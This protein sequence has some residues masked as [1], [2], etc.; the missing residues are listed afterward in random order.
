MAIALALSD[1]TDD[2]LSVWFIKD[3]MI[4]KERSGREKVVETVFE[5]IFK[6]L[7]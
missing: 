6:C 4:Y 1:H 2:Y 7:L 3:N 5:P